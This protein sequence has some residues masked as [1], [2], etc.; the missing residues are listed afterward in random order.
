MHD[1]SPT[2]TQVGEIDQNF[3]GK[4]DLIHF[5]ARVA[6][7]APIHSV[8]LLLQLTYTLQV[9]LRWRMCARVGVD[10]VSRSLRGKAHLVRICIHK[11]IHG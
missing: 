4:P 2:G 1:H 3:D 9:R 8:K 7:T 11:Q 10:V 6:T 5:T